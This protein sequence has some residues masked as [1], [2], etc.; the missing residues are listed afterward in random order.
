MTA[1][2][3]SPQS[4]PGFTSEQTWALRH[5]VREEMEDAIR[6]VLDEDRSPCRHVS[7]LEET[8]YGNSGNGLKLRM[9]ALEEQMNNMVWLSRTTLGAAIVAVIGVIFQAVR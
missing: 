8:V 3:H 7:D 5:V 4:I 6:E 2:A 1:Q 9:V